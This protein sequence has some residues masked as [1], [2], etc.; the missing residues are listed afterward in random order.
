MGDW[1]LDL[2]SL[3]AAPDIRSTAR[4]MYEALRV[5]YGMRRL[6]LVGF[7]LVLA[8]YGLGATGVV[9]LVLAVL[10]WL[11]SALPAAVLAAAVGFLLGNKY[12]CQKALAKLS[13]QGMRLHQ[14]KE[15]RL[16]AIGL[17][18]FDNLP[19][20]HLVIACGRGGFQ[21][22]HWGMEAELKVALAE[23]LRGRL[24]R[25]EVPLASCSDTRLAIIAA[26][27]IG[28]QLAELVDER[29]VPLPPPAFQ[30]I[31]W[32]AQMLHCPPAP[33]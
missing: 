21:A 5:R 27:H 33:S 2:D 19:G 4:W 18:R 30:E 23:K 11:P 24:L 31:D 13:E 15:E 20:Y 29:A 6:G 28:S 7:F 25:V 26:G 8:S 16:T 10:G 9:L 32:T 3:L 12:Y 17:V 22:W 14:E 1:N